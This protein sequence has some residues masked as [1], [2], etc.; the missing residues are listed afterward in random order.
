[1]KG[2]VYRRRINPSIHQRRA[3][4][5]DLISSGASKHHVLGDKLYRDGRKGGGRPRRVKQ[6]FAQLP[7]ASLPAIATERSYP[8]MCRQIYLSVKNARRENII[9]IECNAFRINT[10]ILSIRDCANI[11]FRRDCFIIELCA[12]FLHRL[13]SSIP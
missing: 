5:K 7:P 4:A 3:A 6:K 2:K 11:F 8:A 13:S 10:R 9:F 12:I 1:M